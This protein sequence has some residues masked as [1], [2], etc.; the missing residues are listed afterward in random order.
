[1][2]GVIE[3]LVGVPV[4]TVAVTVGVMVGMGMLRAMGV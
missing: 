1:M 2:S 3:V 4:V